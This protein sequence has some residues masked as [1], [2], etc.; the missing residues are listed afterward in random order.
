MKRFFILF[1]AL[2]FM[3][4]GSALTEVKFGKGEIP[5]NPTISARPDKSYLVHNVGNLWTT[6]S[7]FANYGEPNFLL[8]SGEWPAGSEQYY[9]WE[10]RFW[11][12][13]MVGG[14]ML[15]SHADFGDYEFL[16]SE[17]STFTIAPGKSIQDSYAIFDDNHSTMGSHTPIGV[18]IVQ[19]G[20]TWSMPD[21]YNFVAYEYSVVNISGGTLNNVVLGWIF[22][23]DV[24]AGPGGDTDQANIDDLVDYDGNTGA[25]E[26]NPYKHD[27]VENYDY[28]LDGILGGYDEWGWPYAR[29]DNRAGT[30][31]NPYYNPALAVS[32]GVWDEYQVYVDENGPVIYKS[33]PPTEVLTMANGDTLFG[34]LIPRNMSY[35]YDSDYPSSADNDVGERALTYPGN[36]GFIGGRLIWSDY[37]TDKFDGGKISSNDGII[38][39][40]QEAANDTVLRTFT[41]QWW[42]WNSDPGSDEEKYQYL[43]GQHAFSTNMKFLPHPFSY[44]AGAPTFDYRY[45]QSTGLF[46]GWADLDTIKA[47]YVYGVG[48][49]LEGLRVAMDNA[50][51]AYYSG[52]EFSNPANPSGFDDDIHWLLPIPPQIPNLTYSPAD[53]QVQLVWDET[54]E[55]A[56]DAFV[57]GPDF[58]GY[59]VYRSTYNASA[60]ELI[61]ACDN[62]DNESVYITNTE[63]DTLN[64]TNP[65]DLPGIMDIWPPVADESLSYYNNHTFIDRG[66]VNV[67]GDTVSAPVNGLPYYYAVAAYDPAKYDPETGEM[68][69]SSIESAKNNYK[70]SASGAPDP[71]IPHFQPPESSSTGVLSTDVS[72][73]RVV[74]NPYKGTNLF[75]P[76]YQDVIMFTHL[77]AQCK[78][79]IFSLTGDLVQEIYH[80]DANYGDEPWDL[81]SRN[82]QSVVSGLYLYVVESK[83]DKKVGKMLI[84]R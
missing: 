1:L 13:A 29:E 65:V 11:I 44:Q 49:G 81:I 12:G 38:G 54:S 73:V 30:V 18:K 9:V 83:D 55:T 72:Q 48:L 21:Y 63:G 33:D 37:F 62:R 67:W 40:Y 28:D 57:G 6:T 76:R 80:N 25:S 69:L 66:G 46:N 70:K 39:G 47:V 78:I 64:P 15:C 52:S 27:V 84:I 61:F 74:P 71:V 22:D 32:D 79:S 7:N 45:L 59:K 60:W 10:G 16:P 53:R 35:M 68:S 58:E 77:P 8:P 82:S 75:E 3:I 42:N 5:S 43:T 24:A 2:S 20:L 14:N 51:Y 4:A 19:R 17:G 31:L 41:H 50:I 36:A 56:I 26:T 23:N 34:W